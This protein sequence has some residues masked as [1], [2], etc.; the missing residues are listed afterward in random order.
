[1]YRIPLILSGL[2]LTVF[3]IL[4]I[5]TGT[6]ISTEVSWL[7]V[8]YCSVGAFFVA[9]DLFLLAMSCGVG[10]EKEAFRLEQ[11]MMLPKEFPRALFLF[12]FLVLLTFIAIADIAERRGMLRSK[13]ESL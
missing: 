6:Q 8:A 11:E 3:G 13:T 4:D 7:A 5:L 10:S 9:G 2:M 1:M 12:F